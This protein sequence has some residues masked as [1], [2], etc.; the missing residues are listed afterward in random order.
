MTCDIGGGGVEDEADC[1]ITL[2]ASHAG[3]HGLEV[4][5]ERHGYPTHNQAGVVQEQPAGNM[6]VFVIPLT[7]L[8]VM[9]DVKKQKG[10]FFTM[11]HDLFYLAQ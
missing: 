4:V 5:G 1:L 10:I 8:R 9:I 11:S 7:A 2:D 3:H 6:Q